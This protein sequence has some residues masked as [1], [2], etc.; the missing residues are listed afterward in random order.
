MSYV[1][2]LF[3]LKDTRAVITGG[4]GVIA[5]AMA[6]VL[7]H[8]G[9]SISLWDL[10][11]S[12]SAA[13]T[14][15][16]LADEIES[17]AP[18][19][20]E[21]VD[22]TSVDAIR[23]ALVKTE[24]AIGTPNL[25]VNGVGGNRGKSAF[26]DLDIELFRKVLD[27]N[28]MAGLVIPTKVFAQ[29]WTEKKIPGTIINIASMAS[30]VPLSG[31]WAYDAAK[32]AVLNLTQACAAEFAANGIRVNAIAPG[33]FVGNQNRDLLIANNDT[34]ELT[35][36]GKSIIDHTP[37]GR[38]GSVEELEGA[39]VYLASPKASGFV[40]GVCIPVDGGYLV[41]NI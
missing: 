10:A 8:A 24:S 23:D 3:G 11:T 31:V 26:V 27:L 28:I 6:S 21:S 29:T 9:A 15:A 5:R 37:Y 35:E 32:S 41:S 4:A 19:V 20:G 22:T 14:A 36:R 18:I 39:V 30:Y 2:E 7:R 34:G 25:L 17:E 38:F 33:F 40:T 16:A 13:D 12:P 1:E